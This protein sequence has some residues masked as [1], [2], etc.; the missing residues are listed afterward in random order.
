MRT[1]ELTDNGRF[2][3]PVWLRTGRLIQVDARWG[4]REVKFNPNHD[5]DTGRF[6]FSAGGQAVA[7]TAQ[8]DSDPQARDG[9]TWGGD[10]FSGGGGGTG[11][12]GGATGYYITDDDVR[13]YQAQHPGRDPYLTQ[14]GDTMASIAASHGLVLAELSHLN[15]VASGTK[16]SPGSILALPSG[17][18]QRTEKHGYAFGLDAV[19]RT[20]EAKGG[21]YLANDPKRSRVSQRNAGGVDRRLSDDGGHFIAARFGGPTDAFNHFTQDA[22]FNRGEY[23][24]LEDGWAA[25]IR[26]GKHVS[27]DITAHYSGNSRRPDS[28]TVRSVVNG[29]SSTRIL[30]NKPKGHTRGR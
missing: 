3:F 5:P 23:R 2:S 19:G 25:D 8:L 6:T 28:L 26:L 20:H 27:V 11:G 17:S 7:G 13:A 9:A 15:G 22:S 10:R 14:P 21:L 24:S 4:A 1:N 29:R 18:L 16:L 30:S 12:G